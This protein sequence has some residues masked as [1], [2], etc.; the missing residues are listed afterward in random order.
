MSLQIVNENTVKRN[1]SIPMESKKYTNITIGSIPNR[2]D[3]AES[4]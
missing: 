3:S 4:T 2:T 1:E